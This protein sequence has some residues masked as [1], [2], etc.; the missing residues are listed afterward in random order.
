MTDV[1]FKEVKKP[2]LDYVDSS[3]TEDV[4][5]VRAWEMLQKQPGAS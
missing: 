1:F 2:L 4:G 3:A 5:D